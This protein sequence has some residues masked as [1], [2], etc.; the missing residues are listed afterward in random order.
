MK[1]KVIRSLSV[2]PHVWNRFKTEAAD[3]R[4]S[5]SWLLEELVREFL[6]TEKLV[7]AK[8]R[9]TRAPKLATTADLS[10]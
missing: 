6:T 3:R 5:A 9:K 8:G 1:T 10:A 2:D 4:V 7:K